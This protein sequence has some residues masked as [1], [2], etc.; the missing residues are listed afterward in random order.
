MIFV[1][2]CKKC[3]TFTTIYLTLKKNS[4]KTSIFISIVFLWLKG[5]AH[6]KIYTPT[7]GIF[8]VFRTTGADN[9]ISY[10]PIAADGNLILPGTMN[11]KRLTDTHP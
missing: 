3:S 6:A 7:V 9:Y 4:V 11:N 10:K 5:I 2:L 1:W 8:A